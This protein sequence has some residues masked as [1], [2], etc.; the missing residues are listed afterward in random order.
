MKSLNSKPSLL[1]RPAVA[2]YNSRCENCHSGHSTDPETKLQQIL[3]QNLILFL[4]VRQNSAK[5]NMIVVMIFINCFN[6]NISFK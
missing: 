3:M 1:S 5:Q 6:V 2:V 4:T